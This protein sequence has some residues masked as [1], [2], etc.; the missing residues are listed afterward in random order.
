[1]KAAAV[2]SRQVAG[3]QFS[4]VRSVDGLAAQEPGLTTQIADLQS[5]LDALAAS[6]TDVT[7]A[8]S[9]LDAIQ[10]SLTSASGELDGLAAQALALLPTAAKTQVHTTADAVA[11]ALPGLSDALAGVTS[12]L[13]AFSATYGL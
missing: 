4:T 1:L 12:N 13:G 9:A 5:Q 10:Q 11:A 6:G 7:A 2:G 8:Q 3:T